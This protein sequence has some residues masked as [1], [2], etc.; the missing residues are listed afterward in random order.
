[1]KIERLNSTGS[2]TRIDGDYFSY[3][4]RLSFCIDGQLF[5]NMT[6]YSTTT[7]KHQSNLPCVDFNHTLNYQGYGYAN[8]KKCIQREIEG[9]NA[10]LKNRLT[11]RKTQNNLYE[12]DR[13]SKKIQ[14]LSELYLEKLW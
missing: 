3:D 2:F 9:L 13:V 6:Y 10:E 1:M 8:E 5:I 4:T 12:I 7:R 14:F 11:K